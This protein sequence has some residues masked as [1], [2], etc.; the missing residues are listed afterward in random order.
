M[1]E[2]KKTNSKQIK[3]TVIVVCAVLLVIVGATYAW[4]RLT[5]SGSKINI[6]RAGG[7]ELTLEET[8]EGI[9]LEDVVPVTDTKGLQGKEYTFTLENKG[10]DSSYTI[11]LDDVLDIDSDGENDFTE[12]ERMSDSDIK[13]SL[14]KNGTTTT[15]VLTATGTNP[16]RVLDSGIIKKGT[17]NTYSL[18]LWIKEEAENN[19]IINKIFAAKLR[20]EAEQKSEIL[21][22]VPTYFAFGTPT[23]ASTTDYT[24][25][26]KT[27]FIGLASDGTTKGVCINNGGLLCLKANDYENSVTNLKAYFGESNCVDHGTDYSCNSDNNNYLCSATQDGVVNCDTGSNGSCVLNADGTILCD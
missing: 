17:A 25:L 22:F 26:G 19:S 10:S 16:N 8:S 23:T 3:I 21:A 6:L 11:Y 14:I 5:L 1:E 15:Q 2:K 12:E 24:T 18:R 7:L 9:T 20:I 27:V 13:Y 4:L